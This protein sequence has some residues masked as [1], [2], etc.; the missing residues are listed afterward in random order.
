MFCRYLQSI[1]MCLTSQSHSKTTILPEKNVQNYPLHVKALLLSEE[2][3][4]FFHIQTKSVI[5]PIIHE[6]NICL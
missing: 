6:I 5:L 3:G 2:N 1:G 4:I